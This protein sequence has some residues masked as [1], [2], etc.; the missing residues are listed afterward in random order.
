M[1]NDI[2]E[3][4]EAYS[5]TQG[6]SW[7]WQLA[8]QMADSSFLWPGFSDDIVSEAKSFL[9]NCAGEH[10]QVHAPEQHERIAAAKLLWDDS[11]ARQQIIILT[12]GGVAR[13]Q[14]AERLSVSCE[15]I[16]TIEL[17]FFDVRDRLN[18]TSW[19]THHVI[20][21]E[22][23]N[24]NFDLAIKF[25]S[26]FWRGPNVA[27]AILD[28]EERV[29]FDEV[30]RLAD[31]ELRLSMK[32]QQALDIPFE[33]EQAKLRFTKLY[34]DYRSQKR[35]HELAKEKF[36]HR[37]QEDLRKHELAKLRIEHLIEC[38][39]TKQRGDEQRE[40]AFISQQQAAKAG[41]AESPLSQLTWSPSIQGKATESNQ[42][43]TRDLSHQKDGQVAA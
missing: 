34:M 15:T 38:E 14:I 21:P 6:P 23:Q 30:Q 1:D 32:A 29:S 9:Q 39:K 3:Y 13:E 40:D 5:Q 35:R 12:L 11:N 27:A 20:I 42:A 41:A 37:C 2:K 18:A 25:R 8:H 33:S 22:Q 7:R 4:V 19:I 43:P 36:R 17:L 10:E 24:G 28:A 31:Q 16:T 26:A